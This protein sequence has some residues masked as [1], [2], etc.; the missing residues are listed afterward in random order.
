L[1]GEGIQAVGTIVALG[2][3]GV[4]GYQCLLWLQNG[5]WTPLE[6][7]AAL[8][9]VGAQEPFFDWRGVQKISVWI[10]NQPLSAVMVILGL[11]GMG[12]GVVLAE[13]GYARR[14]ALEPPTKLSD[15]EPLNA[16]LEILVEPA[17][18]DDERTDAG[19]RQ[20]GKLPKP[21]DPTSRW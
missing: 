18:P 6:F 8:E 13:E 20:R 2:G 12:F 14:R 21:P 3:A 17:S 5:N 10:F 11:G 1:I 15:D 16:L 19:Q 9:M 7:R 4:L